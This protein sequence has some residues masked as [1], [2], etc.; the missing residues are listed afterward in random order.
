MIDAIITLFTD[1]IS[2]FQIAGYWFVA[3]VAFLESLAFVGLAVPGVIIIALIGFLSANTE[4]SLAVLLIF[5][6][7]G[8]LAGDQ[9]SFYLGWKGEIFLRGKL[10]RWLK[11][12][13]EKGELFMCKHGNKSILLGRFIGV[14]RP[15]IPFIAGFLKMPFAKFL[16]WS[17]L[18]SFAWAALYLL[19]GYYGGKIWRLVDIWP[20]R[21]GYFLLALIVILSGYYLSKIALRKYGARIFRFGYSVF[22]SMLSA[23]RA[24]PE[25]RKIIKRYPRIFYFIKKR[26]DRKNYFGLMLTILLAVFFW[27]FFLF[28]DVV[29]DVGSLNAIAGA[30]ER[31]ANLLLLFRSP[32]TVSI[33]LGI[34]VLGQFYVV[35][36]VAFA[37]SVILYLRSKLAYA[38]PMLISILGCD[39]FVYIGKF[40]F[41]RPRPIGIGVYT[42]KLYSFPS[43]HA[44]IA[45][46]FYGF[47]AYFIWRNTS[48][49]KVK[50]R[51]LIAGATLIFLIGF[52]RVFL[53]VHFLSDVWGGYMLGF[54]WLVIGVGISEWI[55]YGQKGRITSSRPTAK[56]ILSISALILVQLGFYS[57]YIVKYEVPLF[58]I[59]TKTIQQPSI[60]KDPMEMFGTIGLSRYS[61]TIT[62]RHMEPLSFILL[63][64]DDKDLI[65]SFTASG[66][67]LA[68]QVGMRSIVKFVKAGIYNEGYF[69]SPMTPS[70]W[71]TQ[72]H[73]FGFQ[74]PLETRSISERHHVRCWKTNFKPPDGYNIYVGTASL[75]IGLK[76]GITHAIKPD[77][78]SER[79][80][81]F[82]DLQKKGLVATSSLVQF[83]EPVLGTNFSGDQFFTD[84][85]IY[86]IKLK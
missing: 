80:F 26:L 4:L 44:A 12:Y 16:F 49:L 54:L 34:T 55:R 21:I 42:E 64:K 32:L 14:M 9:V 2:E 82:Q 48:S 50:T 85:K 69:Q 13:L 33:F 53:G 77:I 61:E 52:S 73:D 83:V 45:V 19:L 29:H 18:S 40:I 25:V 22:S 47:L 62:G 8:S 36:G 23:A 35:A 75:D 65:D 79:A 68:D 60:L 51:S 30:D 72:V 78:D 74:K 11:G 28:Y 38:L 67:Y 56:L 70:F 84:G 43:A 10:S 17:S 46:A 37:A 41:R 58:G 7:A 57:L 71:N 5:A 27:G 3:L 24:N 63:A 39:I 20:P 1:T 15:V 6:F 76:W 66:W 86:M 31:I 59:E 81:I